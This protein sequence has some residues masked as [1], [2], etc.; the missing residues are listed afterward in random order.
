MIKAPMK[1]QDLQR[2]IYIKAKTEK[3]HAFWGIYV[4]VC[5]METLEYAYEIAKRNNGAPGIDKVTFEMI[6]TEGEAKFL[7]QIQQELIKKTY[8][9]L[10]NRKQEIPKANG[11]MRVLSIPTIKDRVVQGAL[12]LILEPIFEADFQAGS[13]GY[14]PKRD[15]Q[16]AIESVRQ[17]IC[18]GKTKVIDVDIKAYFDSVR[19]HILLKQV[20]QRILDKDIMHLVK[21]LCKTTG[22]KGIPQGGPLSP[23]LANIYLNEIDKMLEEAKEATKWNNYTNVGYARFADDLVVLISGHTS[24]KGLAQEMAKRLEDGLAKLELEMNPEKTKCVDLI[25]GESFGFVGFDIRLIRSRT[26]DKKRPQITPKKSACQKVKLTIKEICSKYR[27]QAIEKVI[28]LINPIVRGWVNYFRIGN[29][30]NCFKYIKQWI[31][32]KVRRHMAKVRQK[33]GFGWNRWSNDLIYKHL[34]LFNDYQIRYYQEAK[35]KPA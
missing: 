1:L 28:E 9:P 31:N 11:K 14:R 17:A 33:K 5:K 8:K 30:A 35:V 26:D 15:P 12:K 16:K 20:A 3:E 10:P 7:A 2:K 25:E 21:M 18:L 24:Q 19:H 23:L 6:E 22:K 34:G 29:A 27:S 4:H 32:K 13:Y